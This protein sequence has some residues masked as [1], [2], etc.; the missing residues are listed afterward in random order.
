[1]LLL[2]MMWSNKVMRTGCHERRPAVKGFKLYKY[3]VFFFTGTPQFQYQKENPSSNQ[4]WPFLGGSSKKKKR[5]FLG[6][7]P[8]RGGGGS[9]ISQNF[10][11]ITKSFL[12]C[13][14]HPRMLKHVFHTGEVREALP[15]QKC[16]FFPCSKIMM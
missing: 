13:Q 14:I 6:I 7:F 5:Y 4:S 1:M 16:S 3:R 2:L 10:C 15:D 12:A 8:K 11:K 9:P